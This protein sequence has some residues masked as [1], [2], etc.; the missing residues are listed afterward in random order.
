MRF[1]KA[2]TERLEAEFRAEYRPK[3]VARLAND[4]KKTIESRRIK[5][6]KAVG[7]WFLR[8]SSA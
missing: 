2:K 4:V 8:R 5:T 1:S 7:T 6:E 3:M